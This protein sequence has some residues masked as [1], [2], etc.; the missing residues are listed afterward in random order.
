[1][2]HVKTP[3][4]GSPRAPRNT[5]SRNS[6]LLRVF[7]PIAVLTILH[8]S[9]FVG[10]N[11]GTTDDF[12]TVFRAVRGFV[13]GNPI[14]Q[15][16]YQSVEPHFLYSPGGTLLITPLIGYTD[17]VD[18]ARYVF[19]AVQAIAIIAAIA[20]L[21]RWMGVSLRSWVFPASLAAVFITESVTNTIQFTNINGL[22]L[23]MLVGFLILLLKDRGIWAG[24]LL[25]LAIAV[26]PVFAPLLFLPFVRKQ[27]STIGSAL[28]VPVLV[29]IIAWPIMN[30]PREYIDLTMPYLS[31]VRLHANVSLAGQFEY[32]GVSERWLT[33]WQAIIALA[34]I[35]GLALTLR[36][37]NRDPIFWAA[38]SSGL[39]FL[40]G[41]LLLSLGQMYYSMFLFPM[42][43]TLIRVLE[44]R[45]DLEGRPVRSVMASWPAWVAMVLIFGF[46]G[47]WTDQW[48]MGSFW[49][50]V[51]RGMIGWT[52]LAVSVTGI[53]VKWTIDE[54]AAGGDLIPG[55]PMKRRIGAPETASPKGA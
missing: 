7:W 53:L 4:V 45:R 50:D 34:I 42:I 18:V 2:D 33:L 26:K 16:D 10:T 31:E 12:T 5:G 21:I 47:W 20:L 40:A 36:W 23:L 51:G 25:G 15:Q 32:F 44:G 54:V 46:I 28:A 6:I 13:D 38:T 17:D 52:L 41:F 8:R 49:W 11:M 35:V 29:N 48:A 19:L 37:V 39:L 22:L 1:M 9:I 3:I 24:I 55:R 43:F 14:Y 27:F 30:S